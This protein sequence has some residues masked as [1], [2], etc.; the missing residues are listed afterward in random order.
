M[1]PARA[2]PIWSARACGGAGALPSHAPG[3]VARGLHDELPQAHPIDGL[4]LVK[5]DKPL[6]P[7]ASAQQST[8][9][10]QPGAMNELEIHA[11]VLRGDQAHGALDP[12]AE[13][14]PVIRQAPPQYGLSGAWHGLTHQPT[15]GL[16]DLPLP[17][18]QCGQE[19]FRV[20]WRRCWSRSGGPGFLA[21]EPGTG[22]GSVCRG[23]RDVSRAHGCFE[24]RGGFR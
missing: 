5:L 2:D 23:S 8:R 12:A 19:S 24:R 15:Q 7:A 21:G 16:G 4:L 11:G 3:F 13:L 6:L 9:V 14:G 20:C 22:A 17:R 1:L 10:R 18:R